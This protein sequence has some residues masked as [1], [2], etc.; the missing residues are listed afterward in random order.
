V[1]LGEIGWNDMIWIDL[2]YDR[3]QWMAVV[4]TAVYLLIP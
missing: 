2:P 4:N 3:D 1:D